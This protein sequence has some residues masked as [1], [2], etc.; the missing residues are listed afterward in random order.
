VLTTAQAAAVLGVD[1]SQVRR[2]IIDGKL[3]AQRF[4]LRAWM[5]N[6]RDLARFQ[7]QP[8]KAGR[9]TKQTTQEG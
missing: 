5:I 2:L 8:R 4:G 6:E 1:P 3:K 7:Q 9:P